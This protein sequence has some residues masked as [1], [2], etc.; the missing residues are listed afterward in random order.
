MR[1]EM[2][3]PRQVTNL[4]LP[5]GARQGPTLSCASETSSVFFET[6]GRYVGLDVV[7]CDGPTEGTDFPEAPIEVSYQFHEGVLIAAD[8]RFSETAM[9]SAREKL[10]EWFG[11]PNVDDGQFLED[12]LWEYRDVRFQVTHAPGANGIYGVEDTGRLRMLAAHHEPSALDRAL[13][14]AFGV[15]TEEL[16]RQAEGTLSWQGRSSPWTSP[17]YDA[18]RYGTVA[19]IYLS[20]IGTSLHRSDGEKRKLKAFSC[21]YNTDI[22]TATVSG[23][24]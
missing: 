17:Y 9:A 5:L 3:S 24:Y 12:E 1:H 6:D 14:R 4:G 7:V 13:S 11:A 23:G 18:G 19:Y 20:G 8:A 16:Q 10:R 21:R 2:T 22:G 15:C